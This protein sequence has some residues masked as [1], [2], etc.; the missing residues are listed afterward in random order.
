MDTFNVKLAIQQRVLPAYRVPFFDALAER[1]TG[2]LVIFAGQ[3]RSDESIDMAMGLTHAR[4]H[5]ANNLHLGKVGQSTYTLY[6]PGFTG[7]LKQERP[8]GLVV[9][10]NPRY[11]STPAG[12]RWMRA[13]GK[14]VLGWGL[15]APPV[16]GLAGGIIKSA[17]KRLF[18]QLDGLIAYSQAGAAS[19]AAGGFDPGRI[20][21]APNSA[22]FRPR[23]DAPIHPP[24][25][26]RPVRVLF[27]GRLQERKR[28]DLLLQ[29][30]ADL[31]DA[32]QP[33]LTIVGDGPARAGL[34]QLAAQIYPRAAFT[35]ALVGKDLE[36][37]FLQADLFVLPGT[38]GLAVQ[39]ALTHAL[40]VIVGQGD[41]SQSQLV[42]EGNGWLIQPDDL[43]SLLVALR[44]ALATPTRLHQ[45]GKESFRIARDEVN[46]EIMVDAFIR[47]LN[48]VSQP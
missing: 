41:G 6:Q 33:A 22:A 16:N 7:W 25:K 23:G 4:W 24:L 47:A 5:K 43:K 9:E 13:A 45:M 19:Y 14:P 10:A 12:V 18:D 48:Q 46:I 17:R 21:M 2:G 30:C 44:E 38:G 31:P 35:G 26:G 11:L 42:R 40:P 34:Q 27:V 15:G 20:F 1:C 39:Q 32:L 37:Q 8:E 3:P 28:I 36:V 29:A